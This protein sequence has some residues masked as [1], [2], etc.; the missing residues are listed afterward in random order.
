[1]KKKRLFK[2]GMSVLLALALVLSVIGLTGAGVQTVQA[3]T[4]EPSVT[5]FATKDQL[6]NANNFALHTS[7]GSGVAQKVYFGKNPDG[8]VQ[9]W[10]IAGYD[11]NGLVLMCDPEK[12][13]GSDQ[14]FHEN[15]SERNYTVG[16]GDYADGSPTTVLSNHYGSSDFRTYLTQTALDKFT[17]TEK[18]LMKNTTVYTKDLKNNKIYSTSDKLYGAYGAD[19]GKYV[20]VGVNS[21]GNLNGGIK[22][23][24]TSNDAPSG[25]P[26]TSGIGMFWLRAPSSY[27]NI[28]G[29]CV[30]PGVYIV[31][32]VKVTTG[33]DGVPAFDLNLSSVLFASAA[34]AASSSA[35]LEDAM[36][37]RFDAGS[38]ENAR[39]KSIATYTAEGVTVTKDSG[40]SSLY[41][42]VQGNDGSDWVYSK[43]VTA[44]ETV[45]VNTIHSGADLSKCKI[46]LE[47]TTSNVT[48]AKQTTALNDITGAEITLAVPAPGSPLSATATCNTPGILSVTPNVTYKVG[49]DSVTGNAKY[50]TC[51]T[52]SFTLKAD[53]SYAFAAGIA[54][55]DIT[56]NGNPATS[57]ALTDDKTLVVTCQFTTPKAKLTGITKPSDITGVA[58][59][60]EKTAEALGLPPTV[61]IV[62]EDTAVTTA[63]VTWDLVNLA[64]GTYDKTVRTEQTFKVN[65][66]VQLPTEIDQNGVPLTTQISVTVA[67]ADKV[68]KPTANVSS[69]NYTE[70]QN[71][72]LTSSTQDAEIYYTMTTDGSEPAVP[73]TASTEYTGAIPVTGTAGSEV[74][75]RIKAV[76]VK[77]GMQNSEVT[78]LEYT[79]TIPAQT[80]AIT[81]TNGIAMVD[82]AA[83]SNSEAGK[84]VTITADTAAT[85]KKFK[86]WQVISGGITIADSTSAAT[87]FTMPANAVE[88][89]AVYEDEQ[90]TSTPA[91]EPTII[92]QP[93]NI[94][95][96]SGEA[97]TFTIAAGT[98]D[99]GT[100]TYQ[101]YVDRN[102][103]SFAAIEG[104]T[105]TSYTTSAADISCSGYK[106]YCIVK[107]TLGTQFA[108]KQS[109][110]ATLTVHEAGHTHTYADT[111][112]SD[113]D[114]HWHAATCEH[115][116]EKGSYSAHIWDSGV[117]T[118]EATATKEG[119]KTY[120]CTVCNRTKTED[121]PVK[122]M[123]DDNDKDKDD[124]KDK[125]KDDNKDNDKDDN[126]DNDKDDDKDNNKDNNKGNNNDSKTND[127]KTIETTNKSDN[128]TEITAPKTGDSNDLRV[129]FLVFLVSL[130]GMGVLGIFKKKKYFM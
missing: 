79:I 83:V 16:Q 66:T 65:G 9:T 64:E 71:V 24:I 8:Q 109:D 92:T 19:S 121:I 25:S 103:G 78:S 77:S 42:Y 113:A 6:T 82:G 114:G 33:L 5:K 73:T 41:L 93:A 122:E 4:N 104:A 86:E 15:D 101:W 128:K 10:Y 3:V 18:G 47:T 35:T 80:Y 88:V 126:K 46:W 130:S 110:T 67:V 36:T 105:G 58:N 53:S 62:T 107:N 60:T 117:V 31:G 85:G 116:D 125:D 108:T 124:N 68:E 50:N 38:G 97:A 11:N 56:I 91:A 55:N 99:A 127:S 2:K 12:P 106:Y 14:K 13:F 90:T 52:A 21:T 75:I 72:T 123:P 48:Y 1:M 51:Y 89:T 59:G 30:S 26:Y 94:V 43:E 17:E 118:K 29:L 40:D 63:P 84:T 98:S 76:A 22:I 44:S 102:T 39:I 57:I 112:E 100:L 96:T 28:T 111:W 70:D 87:T 120:T 45:D 81:V 49:S 27:A 34:K 7:R 119:V 61:A 115:T 32:N 23:A 54:A 129:W 95:I 37:F 74:T 69:G 20:T